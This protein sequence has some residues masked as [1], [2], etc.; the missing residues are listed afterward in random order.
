MGGDVCLATE[1]HG[2]FEKGQCPGQVALT[3]GQQTDGIIGLHE[4]QRVLNL[5][6][7]PEPFLPGSGTFG[8]HTQLG[9]APREA[10]TRGYTV[11]ENIAEA[12]RTWRT[13]KGCHS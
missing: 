6:S 4:A 12:F 8:E 7:N 9:M 3:Q 5:L 11:E 13:L 10:G 2:P 1:A